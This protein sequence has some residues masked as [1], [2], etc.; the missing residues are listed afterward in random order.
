M[1]PK[2]VKEYW[3]ITKTTIENILADEYMFTFD[4]QNV[5]FCLHGNTV[6]IFNWQNLEGFYVKEEVC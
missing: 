4:G 2:V 1:T 3:V 5:V 6:A